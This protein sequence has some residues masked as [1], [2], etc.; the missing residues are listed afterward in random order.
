[1]SKRF[2]LTIAFLSAFAFFCGWYSFAWIVIGTILVLLLTD[3]EVLKKNVLNAFFLSLIFLLAGFVLNWLSNRFT[4]FLGALRDAEWIKFFTYDVYNVAVKF[5]IAKYLKGILNILEFV[6]MIVF[7]V[8]SLK[9]GEVKVPL[10]NNFALKAMGLMP[11]KAPKEDKKADKD[12]VKEEKAENPLT[13]D[14]AT[15]TDIP[16]SDN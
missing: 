11:A 7:V 12:E 4:G 10:A 9:G 5:D 16:K 15:L 2:G 13:S 1:M 8:M 3:E 14:K 6:L